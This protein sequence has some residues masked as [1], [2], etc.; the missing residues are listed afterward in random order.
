MKDGA[1][2][3]TGSPPPPPRRFSPTLGEIEELKHKLQ[4]ASVEVE[5]LRLAPRPPDHAPSTRPS[6]PRPTPRPRTPF[7]R[8]V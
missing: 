4:N 8:R 6:Y 1:T 5:R 7:A 3:L 2:V